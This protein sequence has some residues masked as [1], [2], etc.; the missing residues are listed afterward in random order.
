MLS[1]NKTVQKNA[2]YPNN[3][4]DRCGISDSKSDTIRIHFLLPMFIQ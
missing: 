1:E 4:I 3:R 2:E